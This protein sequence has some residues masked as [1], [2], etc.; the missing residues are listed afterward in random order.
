MDLEEAVRPLSRS[1]DQEGRGTAMLVGRFDASITWRDISMASSAAEYLLWGSDLWEQY[2]LLND[3]SIKI[4]LI[5]DTNGTEECVYISEV[6]KCM[7]YKTI[8]GERKKMRGVL[9]SG[10][11][12]ERSSTVYSTFLTVWTGPSR[13]VSRS[14]PP[15]QCPQRSRTCG[16]HRCLPRSDLA[17]SDLT[18]AAESAP[19]RQLCNN[20]FV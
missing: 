15:P 3:N 9:I 17:Y 6:S 1:R 2:T 8:L 5:H 20:I 16:G 11:S 10:V 13:P 4:A 14:L 19:Q 7:P 12:L 18:W